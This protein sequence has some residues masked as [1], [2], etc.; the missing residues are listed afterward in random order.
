MVCIIDM[1][2]DRVRLELDS[3]N[4]VH[5]LESNLFI[6]K[7]KINK[8]NLILGRTSDEK[9]VVVNY[10]KHRIAITDDIFMLKNICS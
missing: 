8:L 3:F 2:V 5:K 9:N 10:F 4:I 1:R 7:I 6:T